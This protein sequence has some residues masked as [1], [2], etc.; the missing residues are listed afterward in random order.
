MSRQYLGKKLKRFTPIVILG[1]HVVGI[2]GFLLGGVLTALLPPA[3]SSV[4]VAIFYFIGVV[5]LVSGLWVYFLL[6]EQGSARLFSV[7]CTSA[8]FCFAAYPISESHPI[9][10]YLFLS[11]LG[12]CWASLTNLAFLFPKK[13]PFIQQTPGVYIAAGI[14]IFFIVSI[15]IPYLNTSRTGLFLPPTAMPVSYWITG[16]ILLLFFSSQ[17]YRRVSSPDPV[18]KEQS[19]LILAG[20]LAAFMP[21]LIWGIAHIFPPYPQF[22]YSLLL[23]LVLFPPTFA[24]S[25]LRDPRVMVE[26][27]RFQGLASLVT[28]ALLVS[29]YAL[30][31]TGL[32]LVVGDLFLGG[33]PLWIGLLL[34]AMAV[35]FNPLRERIQVLIEEKFAKSQ[36][37]FRQYLEAFSKELTRATDLDQITTLLR[38]Y[39]LLGV[40]P[41]ILHIYLY[42]PFSGLYEAADGYEGR[43]TS[44]LHFS[45]DSLIIKELETRKGA[46]HIPDPHQPPPELQLEMT[47]LVLLNTRLYIPLPGRDGLVGWMGLGGRISGEYTEKEKSFLETLADQSAL[48]IERAQVFIDLERRMREMKLLTRV[49]QGINVTLAFDDML[50]M[51]YAQTHQAVPTLDFHITLREPDGKYLYHVFYLENDE[52]LAYRE[53]LPLSPDE[54]LE[55]EVIRS[56]RLIVTGDYERECQVHGTAPSTSE[57]YAWMGIPLVAGADI[58]GVISLGNRNPAFTYS[59]EQVNMMKAIADQASGAIVK[60]RL[61]VEA[62]RRTRQLTLLNDVARS[63]TSTLALDRLLSQILESAVEILN[64]EAGSLLMPDEHTGD[65]VFKAAA[66]PVSDYFHEKHLP[67]GTGLV[68]KAFETRRPV[69]S[70]DVHQSKEWYPTADENSGFITR[71]LLVVPMLVKDRVIGVIEVINRKDKL[72]FSPDD[73]ELLSAF[74][75]QAAI[76]I[77]NARLYTLTDQALAARVEELSVMQRIDRELNASLDVSRAMQITLSWAMRQSRAE[78]GMVGMVRED[79]VQIMASEG[80]GSELEGFQEN[81]LPIDLPFIRQTLESDQ[82]WFKKMPSVGSGDSIFWRGRNQFVIPIRRET[83][84]LGILLLENVQGD[85]LEEDMQAFL[86]RLCDHAAIA[87]A[88]AQLYTEIQSANLAKTEFISFVSHELKTPMTSIRGF[89]DLLAKGVVGPV[90][91]NQANF[92]GTIRSNVDRMASLVSDLADLSRIESGKL[93][94]EFSSVPVKQ[95][96]EEVTQSIQAQLGEKRQELSLQIQPD[97]PPFWGDRMRLV[98]ILTNLVSNATKYSPAGSIITIHA[99]AY[100]G[101]KDTGSLRKG[102]AADQADTIH[103]SVQD[104]GFGIEAEEQKNVFQKFFRSPDQKIRDLPGTGLG[105]NITKNLVEMQG[106][107]IWFESKFRQGT[108][109]HFTIPASEAEPS[110]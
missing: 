79:G 97:L 70:E 87:I 49:S 27:L 102:T 38:R 88:N 30:F 100:Q 35:I 5:F 45:P 71:D 93:R 83:Q 73:V 69:L 17:L 64:C 8:A 37:L 101:K 48:A 84:S 33:H 3:Q 19:R 25:I 85:S 40:K 13:L 106:G 1:V 103:V 46:F 47:R 23:P 82:P 86:V 68:G 4:P 98:Q 94:L 80:Y 18:E 2:A 42:N 53:N 110:G 24:Y 67:P 11:A 31:L 81:L 77:E 96:V 20:T 14:P 107:K 32:T 22:S 61:L 52:R 72:P 36:Q 90:N 21:I 34:F 89:T 59:T 50:E 58:I 29:G 105:L 28:G 74:A 10:L 92:L 16:F 57:V 108:T 63:L 44:D 15:S 65:M 43:P 99:R 66:G 54:G 6:N 91:E 104:S 12:L 55:E 41:E 75:S 95:I 51:L 76:A 9:F 62:E 78:A 109:F 39:T 60:A 26:Q 56:G 7:F